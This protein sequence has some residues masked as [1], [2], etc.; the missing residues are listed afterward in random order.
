M[1]V[2]SVEHVGAVG[3]GVGEPDVVELDRDPPASGRRTGSSGSTIAG[4]L[5]ED[6]ED[7]DRGRRGPLPLQQH[8]A[9]HPE[10]RR[11]QDHVGAEGHERA[12]LQVAV[13]RLQSAV[14]QHQG[15]A[16]PG[17]R[18]HHRG[19]GGPGV[20]HLGARPAESSG[21]LG[22]QLE[23]PLL[24]GERLDDPRALDVLVDDRRDVGLP[25]LHDPRQR[26][27]A[28]AEPEPDEEDE[29]Q[30]RERH[31]GQPDVD[32]HHDDD[33]DEQQH[34]L[35]R[36]ERSEGEEQLDR[37]DVGVGPAD[38]LAA[39][40]AVPVAERE[41]GEALVDQVAEVGLDAVGG[42]KQIE[43]IDEPEREPTGG[44]HEE[45]D[46][47]RGDGVAL[48]DGVE[49][50][51]DG[52][53]DHHGGDRGEQSRGDTEQKDGLLGPHHGS[54]S[55]QPTL[56]SNRGRF[57]AGVGENGSRCWAPLASPESG[58]SAEDG[59]IRPN[60]RVH[61]RTTQIEFE[62]FRSTS[63]FGCWPPLRWWPP[64]QRS[65]PPSSRSWPSI[66]PGWTNGPPREALLRRRVQTLLSQISYHLSGAQLGITVTSLMLGF[67]AEP[68]IAAAIE[69]GLEAIFGDLPGGI[70]IA[71]ALAIAT[72]VQMVF[73]ELVPKSL[74]T[75]RPLESS[76]AL[77][78]RP[79][80]TARS[81]APSSGAST[82]SRRGSPVGS[83]WSRPRSSRARPIA[84]SSNT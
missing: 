83:A 63:P 7:A 67:L 62:E 34:Q 65:L 24:L 45:R 18:L 9:D 10:R 76:F 15:Q 5:V 54:Q 28:V 70:S 84:R 13:D 82:V 42:S 11:Q 21:R 31:G 74:A 81:P 2:R 19:V 6:L 69:P 43:A 78:R 25:G 23:L 4:C 59:G 41:L 60:L 68:A 72:V 75:S 50:L 3:H 58:A 44:E 46:D 61:S 12:D 53:G 73:G 57:L 14:E 22:E 38:D 1:N 39:L 17:E 26:E 20:G 66:A 35:H 80:S 36:D 49:P 30:R 37:P 64:M 52:E 71:L 55:A 32:H 56:A 29:R 48:V 77:A 40:D 16:E 79:P 27:D 33:G 8:E 51:S 47:V